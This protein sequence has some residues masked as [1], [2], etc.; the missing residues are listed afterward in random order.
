[1]NS[2]AGTPG[3]FMLT[4]DPANVLHVFTS[5]FANY[6]KG[7]EFSK[8]FDVL[9]DG[10]FNADDDSWAFQR[11]KAHS[12]MSDMRFRSYTNES[13]NNK[14]EN[15]F[16]PL[17]EEMARSGRVVDLQD[18]F[19]RLTFDLTAIFIFGFDPGCL[20][21]GLPV[22]PFAKAMDDAEEILF[23]RHIAPIQWLKLE[24]KYNFGS[25]KRMGK[26]WKVIDQTIADYVS[27]KRDVDH[28]MN[29]SETSKMKFDLLSSYMNC[30]SEVGKEGD[31]FNKFLRDT[32]FNL[33]VAGRD[34]TSSGLAWFFYLLYKNPHVEEKILQEIMLHA[35]DDSP[36]AVELKKL[37]YL[38]AALSE[39]LRL[40]PPVP[41]EHKVALKPDILPTGVPVDSTRRIQ[42]SLYAMARME[43]I[44][45]KDCME[46][47]PER[48]LSDTG[49][50]RFE[51]SYKFMAFNSGP[52][53]C[54]GR[55]LAFMQ[56]KAVVVAIMK[57]YRFEVVPG[58]VARP[59]FSIILHMQDGLKVIV[60]SRA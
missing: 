53:T 40:Y 23:Y 8:I 22:V 20:V 3:D 21:P 30:Q 59:K 55:D 47:K 16:L 1:M 10:I 17:L 44:W 31:D 43:E 34:T 5:N 38:H 14:L 58:F 33:M 48:W 45:G 29:G 52:R 24:K 12:L 6:P 15:Y 42:F 50:L 7:K 4:C 46:F 54:L 27:R 36:T 28:S 35:E 25:Y 51:P 39:S 49:K 56:M 32:T 13:T 37:V 57:R 60:R 26:A 11:R 19:L 18:L 41:F 9:G 2:L